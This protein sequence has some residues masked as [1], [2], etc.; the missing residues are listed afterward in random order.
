MIHRYISFAGVA[1]ILTCIIVMPVHAEEDE[2]IR[3]IPK[4]EAKALI[5]QTNV[6]L[7]DVRYDKNWKKSDM[8]IAGAVR[9]HPNEI[10]SWAGKYAK[11][12]MIILYCD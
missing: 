9:E 7:I 5:G 8:K 12:R 3:R 6:T 1:L 10:G 2:D 11:Y 4:E